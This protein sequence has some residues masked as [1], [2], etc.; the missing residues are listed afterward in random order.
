ME[1]SGNSKSWVSRLLLADKI[2]FEQ[3]NQLQYKSEDKITM[4]LIEDTN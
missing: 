2:D 3:N 1:D 4:S